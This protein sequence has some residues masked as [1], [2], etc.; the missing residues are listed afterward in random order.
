[1]KRRSVLSLPDLNAQ[2]SHDLDTKSTSDL[3]TECKLLDL[4]TECSPALNT[5]CS[6]DLNTECRPDL[7]TER[8]PGLIRN[9]EPILIENVDPTVP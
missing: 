6:P 3:H 7:D 1:M 9:V 4:D 8:R 2:G 5:E